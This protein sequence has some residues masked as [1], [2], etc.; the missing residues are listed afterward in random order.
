VEAEDIV[1]RVATNYIEEALASI[2]HLAKE[3]KLSENKFNFLLSLLAKQNLTRK[4]IV[5]LTLSLFVDGLSTTVPSVLHNLYSLATNPEVQNKAFAEIKEVMGDDDFLTSSH[6]NQLNYIKAV[7]KETFRMYP[8]GTEISR[9]LQSDHVLSNYQVPSQT[10]VSIN[11]GVLFR[12]PDH[13]TA[14]DQFRPERW[15]RG[16]EAD[17]PHPYILT[18]FGV[19]TRTCAGRRFAEQDMYVVLT[20][21]VRNFHLTYKGLEPLELEYNTLLMPAKPLCICFTPRKQ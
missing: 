3:N 15:L 11:M 2:E 10:C 18:P 14:P 4:D 6:L 7:V 8:N 1:V 21:I 16:E 9:I 19:G 12:S 20:E 17:N 5:T 13:F